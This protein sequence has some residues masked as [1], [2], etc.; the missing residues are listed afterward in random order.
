[1][2]RQLTNV[3]QTYGM[4]SSID[5]SGVDL[6]CNSPW[7][8]GIGNPGFVTVH[9]Q[10]LF[11]VFHLFGL[12]LN[13]P[14]IQNCVTFVR[15]CAP[16][17]VCVLMGGLTSSSNIGMCGLLSKTPSPLLVH[18]LSHIHTCICL[19]NLACFPVLLLLML[20]SI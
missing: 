20:L 14:L 17:T 4:L 3:G 5:F 19:G 12:I 13:S 8:H 15:V 11:D 1:M 7:L 10:A 16:R 6:R 9:F 18:C 2:F